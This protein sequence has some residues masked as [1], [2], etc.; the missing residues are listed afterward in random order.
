MF[1]FWAQCTV[2]KLLTF[3]AALADLVED[4]NKF[5]KRV[6]GEQSSHDNHEPVW[7]TELPQTEEDRRRYNTTGAP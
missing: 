6:E 3:A 2:I 1:F 5:N 4:E 7:K